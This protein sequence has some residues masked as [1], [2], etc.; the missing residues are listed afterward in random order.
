MYTASV[1]K[2][3]HAAAIWFRRPAG[4][5]PVAGCRLFLF[6]NSHKTPDAFTLH[7]CMHF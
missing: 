5:Q 7:S 2:I 4:I 1:L 6:A 3:V